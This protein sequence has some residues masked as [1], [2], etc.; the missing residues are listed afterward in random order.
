MLEQER[1]DG[2][3]TG[4]NEES[5]KTNEEISYDLLEKAGIEIEQDSIPK[6]LSFDEY[7]GEALRRAKFRERAEGESRCV[8]IKIDTDRPIAIAFLSDVHLGSAGVDYELLKETAD[9]IREHPLAYC[10]TGGDITDSLFFNANEEVFN[11][12][13]QYI[14]LQKMLEHIGSR[15]IL[16]GIVGNHEAWISNSGVHNYMEFTGKTKRPLL[17]GVSYI[18]LDVGGQEYK[19][20]T[21]HQFK[22]HSYLNPNHPQGR[23]NREIHGADIIMSG[24]THKPAEQS[25]YQQEFGGG[26]KKITLINGKT[27]KRLDNYGKDRGFSAVTDDQLG[28]NWIILSHDRRMIRTASNN[29]EMIETMSRYMGGLGPLDK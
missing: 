17:R 3:Y 10:I 21:S 12:G 13:E 29:A 4:P 25:I 1:K 16:A 9:I 26:T 23:A 18:N 20:M 22:G 15:S 2:L 14:Y 24:H 6:E 28:C 7:H 5:Y 27:F 8:D 11:Q 19:I